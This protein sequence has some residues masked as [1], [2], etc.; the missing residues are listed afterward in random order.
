[1]R[2]LLALLFALVISL[3]SRADMLGQAVEVT[4][5][6]EW[7]S[8]EPGNPG[9]AP[10]PFPTRRYIPRNGRNATVL[11]TVLPNDIT[12]FAITDLP[13]LKR[14]NLLSAQPYL[15]NP[16][17]V[18]PVLELEIPNGIA[19]T[20]TCEDPALV[21]KPV[22]PGEYRIATTASVLLGRKWVIHCTVYYD[23]KDSPELKEALDILR[24]ATLPTEAG[25]ANPTI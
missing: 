9:E 19:V 15:P 14:F 21:G 25:A 6:P 16:E 13:S 7:K 18:P 20:I 24:S 2:P 12:G 10:A 3:P 4:P 22:P 1:M 11:L 17:A 5:H 23:E 8:V